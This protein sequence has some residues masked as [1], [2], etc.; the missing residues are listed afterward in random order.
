MDPLSVSLIKS[1]NGST[2]CIWV[3]GTHGSTVYI[4]KYDNSCSN[5]VYMGS[6]YTWAHT[7]YH[8]FWETDGAKLHTIHYGNRVGHIA[9]DVLRFRWTMLCTGNKED[10]FVACMI[11][12]PIENCACLC[13]SF[14]FRNLKMKIHVIHTK[15]MHFPQHL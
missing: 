4:M 3:L 13:L 1:S 9:H 8:M 12:A 2:V 6:Q 11:S 14:F 5:S 15:S 10:H 7:V